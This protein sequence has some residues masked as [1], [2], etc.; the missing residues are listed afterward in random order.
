MGILRELEAAGTNRS[1]QGAAHSALAF[2]T[3]LFNVFDEA[4]QVLPSINCIFTELVLSS[5]FA[6]SEPPA[7]QEVKRL[8]L[9][10][11]QPLVAVG[12]FRRLLERQSIR[13][14]SYA[15]HIHVTAQN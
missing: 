5:S 11:P 4:M 14:V 2:L 3:I 13:N 7:S 6:L 8:W 12:R 9:K 10:G 15:T 1:P